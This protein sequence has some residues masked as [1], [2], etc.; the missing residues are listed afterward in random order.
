MKRHKKI[1]VLLVG[2]AFAGAACSSDAPTATPPTA[3]EAARSIG[4][5]APLAFVTAPAPLVEGNVAVFD[6]RAQGVNIVAADGDTSG[7]SGHFHVFLDRTVPAPGAAIPKEPGI[8]HTTDSRVTIEGLTI[9]S[10]RVSVVL[11]DGAHRRMGDA[12]LERSFTVEGPSVTIA[13]PATVASG[14]VVPLEIKVEG[15]KLVAADGDRSGQ[16][17]HLHLFIDR[18]P[19]PTGQ[20]I[21]REEGILHTTDTSVSLS[22]LNPGEHTVWVVVGD[23]FHQPFGHAVRAKTTFVVQG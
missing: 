8:L 9:G 6:L 1:G 14:E 16:T 22:G 2:L 21:P 13:A 19:T 18:P 11:G 23:G 10:H 17:G 15:L 20:P 7:R 4:D 3:G 5:S 12:L